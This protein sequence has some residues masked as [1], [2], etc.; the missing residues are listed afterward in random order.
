METS[1]A[2]RAF[3]Q[4][5]ETLRLTVYDDGSGYPTVGWGHKVGLRDRLKIGDTITRERAEGL[6]ALDLVI[7]ED[8]V[9]ALPPNVQLEQHE[10][11]AL[12]SLVWNIGE[13]LFGMSTVRKLLIAGVKSPAADAILKFDKTSVGGGPL[14]T[15]PGLVKRRVAERRLFLTANYDW[16]H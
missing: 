1:A 16:S 5:W 4:G 3:I 7:H 15:S 14:V 13:R 10:F 6:F 12:V 8:P 11:D 2:G 9:R